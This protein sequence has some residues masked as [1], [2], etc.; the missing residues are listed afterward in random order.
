MFF[1]HEEHIHG[2]LSSLDLG[3][4]EARDLAQNWPLCRRMQRY[5]ACYYWI[6]VT[7][8]GALG[9]ALPCSI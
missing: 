7:S 3:I 5:A 8:Y 9:H 4:H 1:I 2:D 6:G